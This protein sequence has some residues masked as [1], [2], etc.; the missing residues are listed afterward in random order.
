M[1]YG[2]PIVVSDDNK[3]EP[4][5]PMPLWKK[6]LFAGAAAVLVLVILVLVFALTGRKKEPETETPTMTETESE[7]KPETEPT[8]EPATEPNTEPE[9][10]PATEPATEPETEPETEPDT[11]PETEPA[12]EPDTE[13]NTQTLYWDRE[14]WESWTSSGANYTGLRID[15]KLN[16]IG[17]R[18]SASAV[19]FGQFTNGQ[20]NGWGTSVY[21][22]GSFYKGTYANDHLEG[23]GIYY[24]ESDGT[25]HI[26][27]YSGGGR[28]GY[29]V[30]LDEDG[31][32]DYAGI[33]ESGFPKEDSQ[34]EDWT[35]E[36]GNRYLG[37]T[38][39]D[40]HMEGTGI[41][42]YT[43][44]EIF[45]G[46]FEDG[47]RKGT[48]IYYW[49]YT[50]TCYVGE[51]DGGKQ[52]TGTIFFANGDCYYGEFQED[53]ITGYGAY[54]WEDGRILWGGWEDGLKEGAGI[55]YRK[56]GT[57]VKG[58]WKED[59][60]DG[61]AIEKGTDGSLEA[62]VYE[63]GEKKSSD[64]LVSNKEEERV[65]Y[66]QMD[67]EGEMTG[68]YVVVDNDSGNPYF[69]DLNSDYRVLFVSGYFYYE[70]TYEEGKQDNGNSIYIL[71][72]GSIRKEVYVNGERQ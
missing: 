28:N 32:V 35:A 64:F 47:E 4:D 59:K 51:F 43:D 13:S 12:T 19:S 20:F 29:G 69:A 16:G 48:G 61:V 37:F 45:V 41:C 5:D 33:R 9:T 22:D 1:L 27:Q 57:C 30:S 60:R 44:G 14:A 67:D 25:R 53:A 66:W 72:D 8:T 21:S 54:F 65:I 58:I 68:N 24:R 34:I 18:E 23:Y 52:G 40:G 62:V 50:E 3:K 46:N 56:D 70:G 39:E 2:D 49:P 15:G 7:T 36:S 17:K 55:F 71:A 26:G 42:I 31:N 6:L 63:A 10:E 11:E 38:N